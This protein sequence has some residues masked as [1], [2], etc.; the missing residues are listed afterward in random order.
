M[1]WRRWENPDHHWVVPAVANHK[2]RIY[3][4]DNV[5][6]DFDRLRLEVTQYLWTPTE[7]DFDISLPFRDYRES[8]EVVIEGTPTPVTP[9]SR[10]ANIPNAIMG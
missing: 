9:N 2:Y 4:G 1:P 5:V 6:L 7:G 10:A 3:F 8:A